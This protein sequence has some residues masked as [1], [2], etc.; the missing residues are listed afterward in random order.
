MV[1]F[2][3]IRKNPTLVAY[4]YYEERNEGA[5]MVLM[6]NKVTGAR[7]ASVAKNTSI[8]RKSVN[9]GICPPGACDKNGGVTKQSLHMGCQ[10]ATTL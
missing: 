7:P 6:A 2:I 5:A 9:A 8:R 1:E 4:I 10:L 3:A